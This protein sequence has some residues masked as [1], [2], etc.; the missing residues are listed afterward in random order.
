MQGRGFG[1]QLGRRRAVQPV[2]HARSVV[3][4]CS[5]GWTRGPQQPESDALPSW[6]GLGTCGHT[7][8][9]NKCQPCM[10]THLVVHFK[11]LK[12]SPL[13]LKNVTAQLRSREE[14][15]GRI[16]GDARG[17][18][19]AG[20][21]GQRVPPTRSGR[22]R[23]APQTAG[24]PVTLGWGPTLHCRPAPRRRRCCSPVDTLEQGA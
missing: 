18:A 8:L 11:M 10:S 24:D 4:R 13:S 21:R 9:C 3:P 20:L 15:E 22:L 12:I 6:R 17:F 23:A 5:A 7:S 14:R 2:P 19:E 16:G 1:L